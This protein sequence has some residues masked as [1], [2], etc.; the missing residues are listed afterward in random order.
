M[1]SKKKKEE[2]KATEKK[3]T[4]K[5][6]TAKKT[7][8]DKQIQAAFKESLPKNPVETRNLTLYGSKSGKSV[9]QPI[10]ARKELPVVKTQDGDLKIDAPQKVINTVIDTNYQ[11]AQTKKKQATTGKKKN[12]ASTTKST[13]GKK[14]SAVLNS[15]SSAT[16]KL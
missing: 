6:T 12:T 9:S 13:S 11:A 2:T 15:G 5:K 7:T 14:S 4:K 8:M 10:M 16:G 1:A 3:E